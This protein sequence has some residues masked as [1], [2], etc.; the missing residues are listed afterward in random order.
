MLKGR[1]ELMPREMCWSGYCDRAFKFELFP[2]LLDGRLNEFLVVSG[3][4][5]PAGL[6]H[7]LF[8]QGS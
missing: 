5:R 4:G 8:S 1:G 3:K 2:R 7:F 6:F